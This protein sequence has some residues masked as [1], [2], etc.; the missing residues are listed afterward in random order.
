MPGPRSNPGGWRKTTDVGSTNHPS[1]PMAMREVV[2]T[3]PLSLRPIAH[4]MGANDPE[5][6][7]HTDSVPDHTNSLK[8]LAAFEGP[9]DES[10]MQA[11]GVTGAQGHREQAQHTAASTQV[12]RPARG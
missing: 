10:A 5:R 11:D 1:Q 8:P 2:V 7:A 6:P 9:M 4:V 3:T 12:T